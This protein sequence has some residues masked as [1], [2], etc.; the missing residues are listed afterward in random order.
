MIF[1]V[2]FIV[3][4]SDIDED[5]NF[6][7]T[8]N[9]NYYTVIFVSNDGTEIAQQTIESGKTAVEPDIPIKEGYVFDG[10]YN[11]N[12]KFDFS[13]P[14]TKDITLMAKWLEN[15]RNTFT[16]IF[17]INND[18]E[19]PITKTQKV[20]KNETVY[21]KTV[22]EL[23]FVRSGYTFIGWN[24]EKDRR[25]V[26]YADGVEFTANENITLYAQWELKSYT[27]IFHSNNE[28]NDEKIQIIQLQTDNI[29]NENTFVYNEYHFYKW[30]TKQD[31]TGI[32]YIDNDSIT[33]IIDEDTDII[34]LYAEWISEIPVI[35]T[36]ENYKTIFENLA[37]LADNSYK[38]YC[39]NDLNEEIFNAIKDAIFNLYEANIHLDF[40]DIGTSCNLY[41]TDRDYSNL[42]SVLLPKYT[43]SYS[44]RFGYYNG[45]KCTN[46]EKVVMAEDTKSISDYAFYGCKKLQNIE[47]PQSVTQ[48]GSYA[49]KECSSLSKVIIPNAVSAIENG[50]F[51][52]C[53]NLSEIIMG[54]NV[55]YIRR[56][57]FAWCGSLEYIT[58]SKN[59]VS[60]GEMAFFLCKKL[61]N[62]EIPETVTHINEQAFKWC[63]K[64]KSIKMGNNVISI[65][66]CAFEECTELESITLSESLTSIEGSVFKGCSNLRNISLPNRLLT[67]GMSAFK[68]CS[69]LKSI[70]IPNK[71]TEID[72]Y[73]F[74]NCSSLQCVIIGKNMEKISPLTFSGCTS[75]LKAEFLTSNDWSLKG[76]AVSSPTT[77]INSEELVN[78]ELAAKYLSDTY[79]SYHWINIAE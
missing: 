74:Q 4:C 36:R 18:T 60:I 62:F 21:L 35:I 78:M 27:I 71:V 13:T 65:A 63:E 40:S 54:D 44:F 48:I 73:A 23:K 29:L 20:Q 3:N 45:N 72:W 30:N 49:F 79:S 52:D 19:T 16:I 51:S 12:S 46:L 50:T 75:L 58:L 42:I 39:H 25:G 14:I 22:D 38:F 11:N 32:S 33:Q 28:N 34:N 66:S 64:L 69:S 5:N 10:W 59:L 77:Q 24:T 56:Q 1:F 70:T 53:S 6:T 76:I 8:Q 43:N 26:D 67:I 68:G 31:G 41:F 61:T 47:I 37:N 57:A 9:T 2:V 17:N 7:E 55:L 15:T